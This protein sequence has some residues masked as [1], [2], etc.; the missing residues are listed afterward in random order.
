MLRPRMSPQHY[1]IEIP[2]VALWVG[3]SKWRMISKGVKTEKY[4][5]RL[6]SASWGQLDRRLKGMESLDS[7]PKPVVVRVAPLQAHKANVV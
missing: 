2:F 5:R 1:L 7:S 3:F 4:R 6:W